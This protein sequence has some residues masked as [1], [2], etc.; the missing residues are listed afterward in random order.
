MSTRITRQGGLVGIETNIG[1]VA[2]TI[3]YM[4]AAVAGAMSEA[5]YNMMDHH[6]RSILKHHRLPGGR[7]AQRFLASRLFIRGR[8]T[9]EQ[10]T[11]IED[12]EGETFAAAERGETFGGSVFKQL[13][14]GARIS[15]SKFMA[16]PIEQGRFRRGGLRTSALFQRLLERKA[17]RIVPARK[18]HVRLLIHEVKA[19]KSRGELRGERSMVV[20]VLTM[21]RTQPAQMGFHSAFDSV[22]NRH[23][24]RLDEVTTKAMTAAGRASLDRRNQLGA[25]ARA[26]ARSAYREALDAGKDRA[27]AR[28][29][30]L[31]AAREFRKAAR[32][33]TP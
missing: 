9:K 3:G 33:G 28:K 25:G 22:A 12:V 17:F 31:D 15:A 26:A 21:R 1:E 7:S 10:P 8:R 14:S 19:G 2:A 29:A 11:R 16:I 13:E 5:M 4:P 20:G 23:L 27:G 24:S 32:G 18:R 6:K 30:S